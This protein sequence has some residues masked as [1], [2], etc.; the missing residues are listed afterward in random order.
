MSHFRNVLETGSVKVV[1]SFPHLK[2]TL[3]LY[4]ENPAIDMVARKALVAKMCYKNDGGASKRIA[5]FILSKI[6]A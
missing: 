1:R 3:S 4:L 5:D 6:N 2:E